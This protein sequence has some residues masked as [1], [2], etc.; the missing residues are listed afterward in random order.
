MVSFMARKGQTFLSRIFSKG[1]D[2]AQKPCA[3]IRVINSR[4]FSNQMGDAHSA[5]QYV[6]SKERVQL[7][8]SHLN[9]IFCF[10]SKYSFD[11][12][13]NVYHNHTAITECHCCAIVV[14]NWGLVLLS[15]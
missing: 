11:G 4:Y 7:R 9:E 15:L 3:L 8:K 5:P 2:I 10:A 13:T 6:K 14:N 12:E 1:K